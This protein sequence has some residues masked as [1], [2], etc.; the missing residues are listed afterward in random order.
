[1]ESSS[2]SNISS[3]QVRR[4]EEALYQLMKETRGGEQ[5]QVIT[6]FSSRL[7]AREVASVS[8]CPFTTTT[9]ID[10]TK[11]RYTLHM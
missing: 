2:S 11:A 9:Q 10:P 5:Q 7:L 3:S 4:L 8:I 1:M 6:A